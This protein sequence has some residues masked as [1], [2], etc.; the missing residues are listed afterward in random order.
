MSGRASD[1]DAGNIV[2]ALAVGG[3][4]RPA[5]RP[6]GRGDD[7]VMGALRAAGFEERDQQFGVDAS[8]C[9]VIANDRQAVD[10][11][12][13]KLAP[14]SSTFTGRDLD[15]YAELGDGDRGNRG[16]VVVIDQVVQVERGAFGLDEDVRVQQEQRQN[17]SSVVNWSR[18]ATSSPLQSVS[19]RWRRRS[20]FASAPV[21]AMAGSS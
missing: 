16:L 4:Q 14:R 13:E 15:S 8:N 7:E 18:K 20:A 10:D 9:Q 2:E 1:F 21:A 17:L 3:D 19:T 11:V 6:C 5:G 12:I